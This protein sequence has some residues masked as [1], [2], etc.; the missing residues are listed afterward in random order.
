MKQGRWK[1]ASAMRGYID[2]GS[3]FLDNAASKV[4]L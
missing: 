2:E 1:S 3:L 4:G